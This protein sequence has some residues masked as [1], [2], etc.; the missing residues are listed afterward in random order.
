M[1]AARRTWDMPAVATAFAARGRGRP[2]RGAPVLIAAALLL[3]GCGAVEAEPVEFGMVEPVG[4]GAADQWPQW[5]GPTRQGI[6]AT[7]GYPDRWSDEQNIVWR[8]A[9]PGRGHSSPIVWGDRIFLTTAYD[10]FVGEPTERILGQQGDRVFLDDAE[11]V[12]SVLC[13]RRSD[14]ELLWET[15][16]PGRAAPEAG[17][18]KSSYASSTPATDGRLV[19]AYFGNH[20]LMAVDFDGKVVWHDHLGEIGNVARGTACSP[21]LYRDRVIIFQD[22]GGPQGS[23]I[24]AFDRQTGRRLWQRVREARHGWSSPIVVRAPTEEGW[25]DEI[26]VGGQ[27]GVNAYNPENGD[28]LWYC[29]GL[30]DEVV[31]T[32][33]V[34][35]GLVFASSGRQGPTLAIRPGGNGDVTDSH[36]VWHELRGSPFVP[37]PLYYEGHLYT[38]NDML[39]V[40]TCLDAA[41]GERMYQV[42]LPGQPTGH[43]ISSS[44]VAVDG[45]VFITTDDG[46]TAVVRAGPEFELLHV[47]RLDAHVFA[48]PA[49]V[50]GRWY[51]RTDAHLLCIGE[52]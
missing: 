16:V 41:T 11:R 36:L 35:E 43:G 46:M 2:R 38:L 13:F 7:G 12:R 18:P 22:H 33:V 4:E 10:Q 51:V 29:A 50:E 40:L 23:F 8:V 6:V 17:W 21:L 24:A 26:V 28:Q 30:T 37:S 25:R 27:H 44:P 32:P 15:F 45:K 34:G 49:L 42:R 39:R 3:G 19:Y 5:R 1:T 31:P 14:G 47:N 48:S 20:G 52:E 9:V